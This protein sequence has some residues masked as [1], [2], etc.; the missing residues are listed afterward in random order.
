MPDDY[1]QEGYI[2]L[3]R[4]IRKSSL[5]KSLKA[6]HRLVML[7]ILLQAQFKD[8]E[9]ARNGEII[10]LK[11]GQ[12][13]TSYQQLVDDIGDKDI[14]IKVVRNAINKLI[15]HEFLVK[16]EEKA[17]SK[18]GL[19]LTISNYDLY[20]NPDNYK[21]QIRSENESKVEALS[22]RSESKTSFLGNVE[23]KAEA[24][25]NPYISS[26]YN[27]IDNDTGKETG[28]M[29]AKQGQSEGKARAINNNVNNDNNVYLLKNEWNR[30]RD[31]SDFDSFKSE[32]QKENGGV[33]STDQSSGEIPFSN[34]KSD[35]VLSTVPNEEEI[36]LFSKSDLEKIESKYIQLRGKGLFLSAKDTKPMIELLKDKIPIETILQGID[37]SFERF[38]PEYKGDSIKHF[39][40]CAR[41]I[42]ELHYMNTD[43]KKE[44]K[45]GERGGKCERDE[46]NSGYP[47]TD[48]GQSTSNVYYDQFPGLFKKI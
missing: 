11:R 27:N 2:I 20:Q 43:R 8:G 12:L 6:T 40:Y 16:D 41:T 25:E 7:E 10:F 22:N 31:N 37:L 38:T 9:V 1:I 15:K 23:G 45:H 35:G 29:R 32:S 17:K 19:L 42:R 28:I 48:R 5:W 36:S 47:Q 3:A 14:T 44:I 4:K 46:R 24:N 18:K 26:F 30:R 34:Q 13:A 21:G 33:P 39:S